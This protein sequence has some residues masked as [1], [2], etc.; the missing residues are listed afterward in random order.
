M[1]PAGKA[2][3]Q[4]ASGT[5]S[6]EAAVAEFMATRAPGRPST[7]GYRATLGRLQ[8]AYPGYLLAAFEP[9]SGA[10][11]IREFLEKTW[12]QKAPARKAPETYRSH[13]SR[14]RTF[15]YW[16][17]DAG[18]LTGDPMVGLTYPA[19]ERKPR[20]T[21]TRAEAEALLNENPSPRDQ[22]PLRLLLTRGVPKSALQKLRF[23]DLDAAQRTITYER[24]GRHT[25]PVEDD[26]FW[27][28]VEALT[29]LRR[30]A[31]EDYVLCYERSR[32]HRVTAADRL[33]M[34]QKGALDDGR[35]YL[36]QKYDGRWYRGE[37]T[38]T[39]RR[40]E[41]GTHLWWYRCVGRAGL[42]PAGATRD[43]R[44]QSARHT[45]GRR[46]YTETGSLTDLAKR[47]GGLGSGGS[48]GEVYRN[49]DALDK[50]IRRVRRRLRL[51]TRDR[52]PTAVGIDGKRPVARWWKEPLRVFAE[53]VDDER[54][55]VELSRVSVAMLRTQ[56]ESSAQLHDAAETLTRAVTAADLVRRAED[57]SSKDH[58]L[59]HG[60]S[61]VAIWSALETMVAD[62]VETWLLWWPPART[63]AAATVSLSGPHGLPP[64]EW[65][66]SAFQALEREYQ[67]LNRKVRSPR[68]LDYYEWLLDVLGLVAD[69]KDDDARIAPNLWEM[70]QIRNVFAHKRGVADARFVANN[71]HLP[72]KVRDEIR[73]DRHA[74]ADFL[75]TTL[76]YAD[77]VARRMRRE[78]GLGASDWLRSAPAP[79]IRYGTR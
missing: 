16:H 61:L 45:V 52:V 9:P 74:W 41:H 58:P 2:R 77:V 33:E 79:V 22:V 66:A 10:A 67:K 60:H 13:L 25:V 70:Q 59:L 46:R 40:G 43:L 73:I 27:S 28:A 6:L 17:R 35:A 47:M 56:K 29:E 69:P 32:M 15:F 62:F 14:L 63:R 26:D 31:P 36:W 30:A 72:F 34:Q 76:L 65:A 48:A 54:D 37:L 8:A 51:D 50:A 5:G 78:L 44:M 12:G 18:N 64:E 23:R 38:P 24:R 71:K 49:P 21:I 3:N 19:I 11:L 20:R 53:Y 4:T 55:L 57:E 75:V 1:A 42:V 7:R 68:R 39:R